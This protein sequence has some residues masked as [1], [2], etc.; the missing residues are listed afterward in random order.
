MNLKVNRAVHGRGLREEN[1]RE[2]YFKYINISKNIKIK[3]IEKNLY[4]DEL[5]NILYTKGPSTIS[6][7]PS[8][9]V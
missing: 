3:L 2:K 6:Y 5:L 4:I 7:M 1:E 9:L 8:I